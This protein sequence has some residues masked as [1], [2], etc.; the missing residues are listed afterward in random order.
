MELFPA[1][2]VFIILLYVGLLALWRSR[3]PHC[4]KYLAAEVI[5]RTNIPEVTY[6]QERQRV[7][8][9]CKFCGHEWREVRGGERRPPS[10]PFLF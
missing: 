1:F 9:R 7:T 10:G 8:F 2:I 3:C 6:Y 5:G 4:A